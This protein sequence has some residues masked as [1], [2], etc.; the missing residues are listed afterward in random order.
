LKEDHDHAKRLATLLGRIPTIAVNLD[1]VE[2]NI[3]L[4]EV[5]TAQLP[6]QDVLQRLR[7]AGVLIN[8]VGGMCFRA[9]THLDV[10][11][12]DINQAGKIIGEA[13]RSQ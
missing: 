5:K 6:A 9:V 2:T 11:A 12:D 7:E 1:D 3:V 8:S 13:L 10:S 4:F